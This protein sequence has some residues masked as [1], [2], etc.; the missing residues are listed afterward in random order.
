VSGAIIGYATGARPS[1]ESEYPWPHRA[2]AL[3][4]L[5]CSRYASTKRDDVSRGSSAA[6]LPSGGR[7][8]SGTCYRSEASSRSSSVGAS[9]GSSLRTPLSHL[10]LRLAGRVRDF[11]LEESS[12]S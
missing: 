7:V 1:S 3:M 6:V 9:A 5:G 11:V 12:F 4:A 2:S 10:D 8:S